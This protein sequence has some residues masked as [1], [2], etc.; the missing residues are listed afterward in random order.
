MS[1]I[2]R[3]IVLII[4]ILAVYILWPRN[5]DLAKF[6]PKSVAELEAKAWVAASKADAFGSAK[7]FY[8]LYDRQ[9]GFPPIASVMLAQS[10]SRALLLIRRGADEADQE[11]ALPVLTE[12][13]TRMKRELGKDWDSPALARRHYSIWLNVANG[14]KPEDISKLIVDLWT[15]VYGSEAGSLTAA[16]KERAEAMIASAAVMPDGTGDLMTTKSLL[17]ASWEKVKAAVEKP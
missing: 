15:S 3:L 14:G 9:F 12:L 11:K 4:I 2:I 16:A 10:S 6:S 17:D 7:S 8:I 13:Y 5:P 1:F